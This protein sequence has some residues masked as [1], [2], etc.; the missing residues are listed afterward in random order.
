MKKNHTRV[1]LMSCNRLFKS[2]QDPRIIQAPP[3]LDLDLYFL[4]SLLTGRSETLIITVG[5][6]FDSLYIHGQYWIYSVQHQI[7]KTTKRVLWLQIKWLVYNEVIATL[8]CFENGFQHHPLLFESFKNTI[9]GFRFITDRVHS[10]T[11]V[12]IFA[13]VWSKVL[14]VG[15]LNFCSHG[16]FRRYLRRPAQGIPSFS[17]SL[18]IRTS[19]IYVNIKLKNN[20]V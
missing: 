15:Y 2:C 10:M 14:S 13:G 6:S 5:K 9:V 12:Y 7:Q 16:L 4:L 20:K 1:K 17:S 11:G 18:D 8:N 3:L 19:A